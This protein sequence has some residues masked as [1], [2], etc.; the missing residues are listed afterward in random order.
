MAGVIRIFLHFTVVG[1][2][3]GLVFLCFAFVRGPVDD[4]IMSFK[5]PFPRAFFIVP[6]IGLCAGAFGLIVGLT[7]EAMCRI[8]DLW[9][10][11]V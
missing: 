4:F 10:R 5:S 8:C 2:A 6:V 3:I 9:R 11:D 1:L 7:W